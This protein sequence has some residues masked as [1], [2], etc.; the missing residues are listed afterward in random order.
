M[1]G[2]TNE[3]STIA[4]TLPQ[5]FAAATQS[6]AHTLSQS[7]HSLHFRTSFTWVVDPVLNEVYIEYLNQV[8]EGATKAHRAPIRGSVSIKQSSRVCSTQQLH[9][10][11]NRVDCPTFTSSQIPP[12]SNMPRTKKGGRQKNPTRN[13]TTTTGNQ[14][15]ITT[16]MGRKNTRQTRS[17]KK[18][19][20]ANVPRPTKRKANTTEDQPRRKRLRTSTPVCEESKF[21]S[22]DDNEEFD[23]TPLT[24]A[25][26][27]KNRRGYT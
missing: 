12:S 20:Q 14:V 26:I 23:D 3:S 13:S 10:T 17:G 19:S 18:S 27:A 21:S 11:L 6:V 15:S 8:N 25:D 2:N 24:K 7:L 22:G 1:A 5:A 9:Q 16:S 4:K